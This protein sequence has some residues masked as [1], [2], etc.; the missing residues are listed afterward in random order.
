MIVYLA[1][2]RGFC[3]G[4]KRSIRLAEKALADKEPPVFVLKDIVH[5]KTVVNRLAE[6]GL[7]KV[8]DPQKAE[9]GTLIFSAHGVPGDFIIDA[10]KRGLEV[11]DTTCPLV[12]RIHKTARE[13]TA[14]DYEV[15]LFGDPDH[16]EV[17]AIK[18]VNPDH[19][20]VL[21][22]IEDIP[23]LP[24]FDNSISFISQSTRNVEKFHE[25]AEAL[26]DQYGP[27]KI[28]NTICLAT[29]RRQ[30]SIKEIVKSAELIVVVGSKHSA[31]SNRLVELADKSGA[32]A[33]LIDNA[34]DFDFDLLDDIESVGITSGASTPDNLVQELI[35]EIRQYCEDEERGCELIEL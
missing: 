16:D 17:I 1:K 3:S 33:Y 9:S 7:V 19:I 24:E 18:S 34:D 4:V 5:N 6:E 29:R 32:E 8:D 27:V 14:K 13:L 22:S 31:N 28:E 21:K 15:I 26:M 30:D 35:A 2:Y 25:A 10:Q 12:Y 11:V 20:H 23:S